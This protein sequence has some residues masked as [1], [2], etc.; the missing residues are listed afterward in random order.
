MADVCPGCFADASAALSNPAA[1]GNALDNSFL[2]YVALAGENNALTFSQ[3][4]FLASQSSRPVALDVPA[5]GVW[6]RWNGTLGVALSYASTAITAS[7]RALRE[8]RGLSES[9][10]R[11]VLG[12]MTLGP[13]KAH[14]LTGTSRTHAILS[15]GI[16]YGREIPVRLRD[17]KFLVGSAVRVEL[18]AS[19][20][21]YQFDVTDWSQASS[22]VSAA[23]ASRNHV[24]HTRAQDA[25]GWG[26]DVGALLTGPGGFSFSF[27]AQNLWAETLWHDAHVWTGCFEPSPSGGRLCEEPIAPAPTPDAQGNWPAPRAA[28]VCSCLGPAGL[29]PNGNP[30][31]PED[32]T[33]R[34]GCRT[35]AIRQIH[36]PVLRHDLS[37]RPPRWRRFDGAVGFGVDADTGERW[38]DGTPRHK[39]YRFRAGGQ[40]GHGPW[41]ARLGYSSR[42]AYYDLLPEQ[43]EGGDWTAGIAYES[44]SLWI[45]N[46]IST[47]EK[48]RADSFAP[49]ISLGVTA[50]F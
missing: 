13:G 45:E 24:L 26:M 48:L 8:D 39:Q 2:S 36:R 18:G 3:A 14:S 21:E 1:L 15:Y 31:P 20:S 30:D 49:M 29:Y 47:A 9:A 40:A 44:G 25:A 42:F 23:T 43:H 27:S 16:A 38:I 4:M 11:A 6:G 46:A 34:P 33:T 7:F 35:M 17:W 32:C 19:L 10:I 5:R 41:K 28:P 37:W 22:G 12:D 50:R